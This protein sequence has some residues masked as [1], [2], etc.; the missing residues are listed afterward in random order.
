MKTISVV[1]PTFN[2]ESTLHQCLESIIRQGY[3]KE[4][5]ELIIVDDKS[6]DNTINIAKEYDA[7]ILVNGYRN[8]EIGKS[9]GLENAK[10]ELILFMDSD[11]VLTSSDIILKLVKPFTEHPEIVGAT[12]AWYYYDKR[13]SLSDRFSSLF[14]AYD[15][16]AFYLKRRDRFM[17]TEKSWNLCGKT[18]DTG[19]YY[20]VTFKED[21]VPT[22]GGTLFLA[23][24]DLLLKT[25]FSPYFFH[26]DSY[27]ELIKMGY[28]KFA[29]V[30]LSFKHFH[31]K[32]VFTSIRKLKRNIDLFLTLK[33]KRRFTWV[34]P[35][36]KLFL[37]A[38][39][40]ATLIKPTLDSVKGYR[41]LPDIAW[42]LNPIMSL[43]TVLIYGATHVV[44]KLK[45][46]IKH[47]S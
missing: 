9:I 46:R 11:V 41:R 5:I 29:Y 34:P 38:I 20:L 22:I 16:L 44:W 21:E 30:K 19:D 24:R 13:D 45:A 47:G 36:Y 37:T 39:L 15:S 23:S 33:S 7:R 17:W 3:P 25:D 32:T 2:S 27:Y 4:K 28:T 12:P 14:G 6:T 10:N 35:S 40:M 1:I 43:L 31:S 26:M 42:F 18:E 8:I